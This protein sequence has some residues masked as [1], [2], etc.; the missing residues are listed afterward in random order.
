MKP[1]KNDPCPCGS[2][3][4]YKKCCG[5]SQTYPKVVGGNH[6][7]QAVQAFERGAYRDAQALCA[8]LLRNDPE[9]PD[10][11]HLCG[12]V[13]YRLGDLTDARTLLEK[14]AR[15]TPMNAL[16]FSNLSFVLRDAGVVEI[17]EDC[18]RRAIAIDAKLAEAHNNLGTLLQDRKNFTEASSAFRRAAELEPRNPLFRCNLAGVLHA[19][20]E[21]AEAK[22]AYLGALAVAPQFAPALAGLGALCLQERSWQEARDYL[23]RA[24]RA[25]AKEAVVR[26]NLGLAL[27][28]LKDPK[29]AIECYRQAL[30][31]S[32]EYGG[33]Y[34]NL[35]LALE[36]LG[37]SKAALE[38]YNRALLQGHLVTDNSPSSPLYTS[39]ALKALFYKTTESGQVDSVLPLALSLL[40][41]A[42]APVELLP[43]MIGLF[44]VACDF[45]ARHE[46]WR[47]FSKH[48]ANSKV[49]EQVLGEALM[50]S[51]YENTL[52]EQEVVYFH[53]LWG[54]MVEE[55]LA[56][57][58][59]ASHRPVGDS[60]R[61]RI[62]YLS[63]DFRQ[64]SVGYFIQH[65][66]A[67]HDHD[68]FEIIC[69]SLVKKP[70]DVT[71]F[72]KAHADGFHEVGELDDV[73]LA[74]RIH[75]DGIQLLVDL[76]GHTADNALRAL[77][78]RPAAL[79]LTWIGYLHTT[80][81]KSVDYRI[82]DPYADDPSAERGTERLLTLPASFLCFSTFPECARAVLPPCIRI[83][84]I[85]F[86]SFNNFMKLTD[87]VVR[88]W[89]QVLL[90][91][92]DSRL[93]LMTKGADSIIVQQNLRTEFAKHGIAPERIIFEKPIPRVEYLRTHNDI[94]IILDT[95]PFNGGT[96]T[97]G[98]LWM[99]VP[100]VTLVG[101]AHRQRVTFSMLKNI[102]VEDTIAW[103][104]NQYVEIAVRLARDPQALADLRQRIAQQTR[105]SILCDVPRFTRQME[106]AFQQACKEFAV[107]DGKT[108][109]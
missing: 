108:S 59:H 10:A 82:T 43:A 47:C 63:P 62:G 38:A 97:A 24:I 78:L 28:K 53:R 100:V 51:A 98:A 48:I 88:I 61:L 55:R 22:Q 106:A 74:K 3:K 80:G 92:S 42:V 52:S 58:R 93:M 75:A 86:A 21:Q 54:E 41:D 27:Y 94:D 79:Q 84:H 37:N 34:Y 64:H 102:G 4:K 35:G 31:I 68:A 26:N 85:T 15:L 25:G 73:A 13:S 23:E 39:H 11:N 8:E 1:E 105:Q 2:G 66:I 50:L 19:Q 57:Q 77:A 91:V 109:K 12:L 95:W 72:I 69:Y 29:A 5:A 33:A 16:I 56:P 6:F 32:P 7:Q 9:H 103:S 14:A 89:A 49:D 76:A 46:A 70:D 81:L 30:D 83:G 18:A 44:G 40:H 104:E 17:A 96:V 90:Q 45:K 87:D 99:G 67:N 71:A 107:Q 36:D 101:K 20:N 65:V 60:G